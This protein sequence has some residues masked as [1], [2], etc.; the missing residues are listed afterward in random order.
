MY[1]VLMYDQTDHPSDMVSMAVIDHFYDY[2]YMTMF[3][4]DVID[5]VVIFVF[6]YL[7][8]FFEVRRVV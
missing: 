4:L 2:D 7:K 6:R 8:R 1:I 5:R 3:S